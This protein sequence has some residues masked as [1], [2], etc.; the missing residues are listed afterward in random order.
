MN[1]YIYNECIYL[2]I[3]KCIYIYIYVYLPI[4]YC[5]EWIYVFMQTQNTTNEYIYIYTLTSNGST[6]S[7]PVV[8]SE[9]LHI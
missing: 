9:P 2:Y 8:A 1:I 3:Q 7:S 4:T 6:L 5:K